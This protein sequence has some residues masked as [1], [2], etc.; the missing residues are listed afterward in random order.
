MRM[1]NAYA[2]AM[3]GL[4]PKCVSRKRF[5]SE[6]PSVERWLNVDLCEGRCAMNRV[7][8]F[9]AYFF[10]LVALVVCL[11]HGW[12]ECVFLV[13]CYLGAYTYMRHK[14]DEPKDAD[15]V[16]FNECWRW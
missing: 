7:I 16:D 9:A 15:E 13:S 6:V 5:E 14:D 3:L 4:E 8:D 2:G 1:S 10:G 12:L 11:F